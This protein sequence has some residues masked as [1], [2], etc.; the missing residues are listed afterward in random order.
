MCEQPR[1]P[2]PLAR[3]LESARRARRLT[4]REVARRVGRCWRSIHNWESGAV[5]PSL[6]M[7]LRL[8]DVYRVR[9]ERLLFEP[10]ADFRAS[11]G[12]DAHAD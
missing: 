11:F 8:A 12:G 2:L 1:P 3:N 6:A 7:V 10:S 4:L 9:A 5:E